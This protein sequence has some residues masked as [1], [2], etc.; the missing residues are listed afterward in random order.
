MALA[1]KKRIIKTEPPTPVESH[2]ESSPSPLQKGGVSGNRLEV[3][4]K[5]N[6]LYQ[7][8]A[9]NPSSLTQRFLEL[10]VSNLEAESGSLW[11][12][13]EKTKQ[14]ICKVAVGTGAKDIVNTSTPVG[15]GIVGCV[16]ESKRPLIINDV[17]TEKRFVAQVDGGPI[18]KARTLLVCPLIYREELIGIIELINKKTDTG[19][20]DKTDEIFLADICLPAAMH[21]KTSLTLRKQNELIKK[22]DVLRNLQEIFSSTM[23]LDKLLQLVLTKAIELLNAEVGSIWLVDDGGQGIECHIAEGPTK[24]KVIGVKVE[25]GKGIIGWVI[26]NHKSKIVEDCSKDPHFSTALDKKI[27]FVTETMIS[28][29]LMVRGEC[30]GAIQIINKK[31]TDHRFFTMEDLD[32]AEV[33]ASSSAMYIKNAK[34]YASEKKAKE[35]AALIT[36]SKEITATLDLNSVLMSIVNL[37]ADVIPYDRAVISTFNSASEKFD[38]RAIS[39][40]E[41]I[42]DEDPDLAIF[43]TLHNYTA[44]QKEEICINS[45]DEYFKNQNVHTE[46]KKFLEDNNHQSFWAVTLKDDQGSLGVLSMEAKLPGMIGPNHKELLSLLVS[47]CTVALRNAELYN[48]IPSGK[49]LETIQSNFLNS[50]LKLRHWPLKRYRNIGLSVLG[51]ILALVFLK[52]PYTIST[53]VEIVPIATTYYAESK[54]IIE[55]VY[56]KEGQTVKAGDLLAK[57]DVA[58]LII[59]KSEKESQREKIKSEMIKLMIDNKASDFAIKNNERTSLEY[60]I[61]RM[62]NQIA[63]AEVRADHPGVVV[64]DKIN[65]LI[66]KPVNFGTELIKVARSDSL[67]VEFQVPEEDVIHVAAQQKVKFKVFG[68]PNTSFSDG[69]KLESVAGEARKVSEQDPIK[70]FIAR[71]PIKG[72]DD[73]PLRPGMTGRGRIVTASKSLGFVLFSRPLR[74]IIMKLF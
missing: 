25:K 61:E 74:Y 22:L 16:A 15:K 2:T 32:F 70:Y 36:I 53:N 19:H 34:L 6:E 50:I 1:L 18:A 27:N 21:T 69:I 20:F 30:I 47:Q 38:V 48:T 73:T 29:P 72:A 26:E 60:E 24:D 35:L 3:F 33:F 28:V 64:S 59:Q 65:D 55:R 71:A 54:G 42:D 62:A 57:L 23:D 44:Q 12:F 10:I 56:V 41:K 11:L 7:A 4:H 17:Y 67:Y 43:T 63:K 5:I 40:K 49:V 51:V 58:E 52:I 68:L 39:G 14:L 46:I 8:N 31:S 9:V 13:K 66:G 37:S 45:R